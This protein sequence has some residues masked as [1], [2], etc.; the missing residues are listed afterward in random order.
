MIWGFP[1][2]KGGYGG[3]AG[4]YRVWGLGFRGQGFPKIGGYLAIEVPPFKETTISDISET[5]HSFLLCLL[6]PVSGESATRV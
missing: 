4:T 5:W 3:Y 1:K 6:L 2:V